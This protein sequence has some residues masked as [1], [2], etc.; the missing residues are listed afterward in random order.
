MAGL[1]IQGLNKSFGRVWVLKDVDLDIADREFVVFVGPSGC[2]KST[3]LRTIAGLE[4]HETGRIHLDGTDIT[5]AEPADRGV[6]MVFQSYAL[7]P[8]M[9]VRGNMSFGLKL[10][11]TSPSEIAERVQNAARTLQIDSLLDRKPRQLSGGQRQRVAI[12]RAIVRDPKI[13]LFD[14]PLSNLDAALRVEMRLELARLRDTLQTTMIY[15]THDQVEAM[16]LADRIVVLNEGRIEQMGAPLEV[17]RKPRTKFVAEFIGSPR[18][19]MFGGR[20]TGG[21]NGGVQVDLLGQ[22]IALPYVAGDRP[23]VSLGIR[24]EHVQLGAPGELPFAGTVRL[25]EHLGNQL[26]AHVA[27]DD[28]PEPPM[29]QVVISGD[30]DLDAGATV[31]LGLPADSVHLF[32][33]DGMALG[34]A[35]A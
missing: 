30:Q 18:M 29:C 17:Y 26:V 31:S 28:G 1:Q 8:H 35:S 23:D 22:H 32:G 20:V 15:V 10:N 4:E 11:R 24:P 3:L 14:E 25:A 34:R 16:T 5:D 27:L 13:F 9:T 21:G 7:F 12:G 6:S 19:N 33:D 2:G